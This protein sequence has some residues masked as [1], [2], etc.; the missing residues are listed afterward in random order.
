MDNSLERIRRM[1]RMMDGME[2][3]ERELMAE[4]IERLKHWM[5]KGQ[6]M[7]PWILRFLVR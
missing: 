6:T 4:K 2:P 5:E 3:G 7:L 1:E